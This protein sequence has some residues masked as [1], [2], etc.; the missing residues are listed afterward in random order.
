[1]HSRYSRHF[2]VGYDFDDAPRASGSILTCPDDI[3]DAN[4]LRVKSTDVIGDYTVK[5]KLIGENSYES[6]FV[7]TGTVDTTVDITLYDRI[8]LCSTNALT[9]G[10]LALSS[11][12]TY[13]DVTNNMPAGTATA[14]NQVISN[15]LLTQI[16]Q[17]LQDDVDCAINPSVSN[18]NVTVANSVFDIV[19]PVDTKKFL[20]R[21]RN[22]GSIEFAFEPT[23]SA[24]FT[25]PKGNSY[26]ESGLCTVSTTIYVRSD[27]TGTIEVITWT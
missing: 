3:K 24:F 5:A 6:I 26:S 25:I 13:G 27:K 7:G 15:D 19:L 21:H 10:T 18:L 16:L 9:G 22:K 8:Q 12:V 17:D 11:F 14:G 23:L 1:M 4:L 2:S 20:I